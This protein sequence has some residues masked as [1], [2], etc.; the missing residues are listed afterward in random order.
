MTNDPGN[1]RHSLLVTT[2]W[3]RDHLDDPALRI[4]DTRKADGYAASHIPGALCLDASPFLRDNGDV[5]GTQEF[6]QIMSRLGIDAG[7]SVVA[8]DDGKNLFAARLWWVL[9]YYGHADVRVLDGGWDRWAAE[10]KPCDNHETVA[11]PAR[12]E[13]KISDRWKADSDTVE[14]AI[15]SPE[16]VI[17][18]VRSEDEWLRIEESG[19]TP[20][21]HIPGA[22]HLVWSEVINP[23]DMCFKPTADL[24]VLFHDIGL[25]QE[26]EILVYC[27]GGI[28]AAHSVLA[29][30]L[31]GFAHARNYEGSWAAWSRA[32]RPIEKASSLAR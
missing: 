28:R 2:A 32:D 27:L 19:S 25:R 16:R 21:G 30:R 20:P 5:T 22:L 7:T 24:R 23:D 10:N 13:P 11:S 29:L 3:V 8:Y 18:D 14:A 6:A 31:A 26:Q 9:K 4:V 17:L 1:S 12:F 15:A